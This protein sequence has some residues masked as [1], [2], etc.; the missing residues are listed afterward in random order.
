MIDYEIKLVLCD[1]FKAETKIF[2][3]LVYRANPETP[4]RYDR[5]EVVKE[6]R[7]DSNWTYYIVNEEYLGR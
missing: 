7:L 6:K 2:H 1:N 4:I 3:H 5:D